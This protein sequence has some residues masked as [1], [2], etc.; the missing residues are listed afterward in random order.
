[1]HFKMIIVFAEDDKTEAIMDA[2]REAGATGAT[3]ITN[4]RGEGLQVFPK[5]LADHAFEA[6][7]TGGTGA[8]LFRYSQAQPRVI[9]VVDP[10]EHTEIAILGIS[11]TRKNAP[12]LIRLG[13]S[14]RAFE[15]LVA[16]GQDA[17]A[18]PWAWI[19]RSGGRNESRS[20]ASTRGEYSA[21]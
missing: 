14:R 16:A 9:Q 21:V 8:D 17:T 20:S 10:A 7:S 11:R 2:A 4:A 1:M 18:T 19:G 3:V 6:V 15:L 13:E 5:A 12:K